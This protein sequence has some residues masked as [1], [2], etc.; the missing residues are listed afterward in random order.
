MKKMRLSKKPSTEENRLFNQIKKHIKTHEEAF[1]F[2]LT[3]MGMMS[4]MLDFITETYG[5]EKRIHELPERTKYAIAQAFY[6]YKL[7]GAMAR[8]EVDEG[9]VDVRWMPIEDDAWSA[10][11]KISAR[12]ILIVKELH[13]HL[14]AEGKL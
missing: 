13:R 10:D 11:E 3:Y 4:I 9:G 5:N 2:M 7:L 6:H 8:G 12:M 14:Q 1:S